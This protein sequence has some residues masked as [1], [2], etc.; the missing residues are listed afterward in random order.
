V[1]S[2]ADVTVSGFKTLDQSS[3]NQIPKF[4]QELSNEFDDS[5]EGPRNLAPA[6]SVPLLGTIRAACER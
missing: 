1:S 6:R 2:E 5:F 3:G 4:R